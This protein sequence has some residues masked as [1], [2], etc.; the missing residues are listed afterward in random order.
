[1]IKEPDRLEQKI[2]LI[3]QA[4]I[5]KGLCERARKDFADMAVS[6]HY[7]KDDVVLQ[8]HDPCSAFILVEH[9][10]IRVSRYSA[11][12]K[13]LTYLLS[14]PGEPIN[15]VGPFTGD[16]RAYV[17]EAVLDSTIL[18][19]NRKD[20]LAFAFANHQLIINII[21][22]LGHAVDSSNTRILDMYE[23]KVIQRLKLVLHTLFQK[24]GPTLNFTAEEIAELASTT[25]E[26]SLRVLTDL[27]SNGIIDKSRGQ[28]HI[29][30]PEALTDATTEDL[31]L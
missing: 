18:S 10:L 5:F 9:G 11:L 26:S 27:R 4:V 7:A 13:R 19:V 25:T 8:S 31:W 17:A 1:M 28:I 30:T 20:F 6:I 29:L 16:P 3:S 12:G 22:T 21:D 15:L 24:F 2:A 14:G 23:K